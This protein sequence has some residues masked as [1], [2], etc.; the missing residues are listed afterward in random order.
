MPHLKSAF[1]NLRKSRQRAAQNRK[2]KE[3]LKRLLK[4]P[5]T[6]KTLP[7]LY[8]EI[9]KAVRRKILPPN[10]AARMKSSLAKRVKV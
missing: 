6:K 4:G 1:K 2:V 8:K 10:K 7:T 5:A 9:D 3:N